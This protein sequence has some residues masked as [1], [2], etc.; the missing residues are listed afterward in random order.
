M[1]SPLAHGHPGD[2]AIHQLG[3]QLAHAATPARG[4]EAPAFAAE[5]HDHL[6]AALLAPDVHAAVFDPATAQVG[7]EFAGDEG[8][9]PVAAALVGSAGQEGLEWRS[10]VR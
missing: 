1:G 4:A 10:R 9:Q 2:D 3:G 5:G 6:I 8:G 7:A